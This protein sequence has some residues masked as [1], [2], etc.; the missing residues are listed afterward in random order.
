MLNQV[1]N[2]DC[3]EGMK[4]IEDKSIDMI[5]CDLPYGTTSCK[6]DSIIPFDKLWEQYERIIKDNGAIVLTASQPFTT[7]LIESNIKLFRY[8]WIWK[9]GNHTTGFPNANRMPLK[10]HENILVFYKKLPTYNPQGLIKLENPIKKKKTPNI[11]V[12]G[13][14]NNKSLNKVHVTSYT[15]YP[16]S[17]IDFSRDSK[18]FHPT[19]KPV[20]LF[21]YLIKTYTN[22]GE[23]VLDNCMGSFTTAIACINTNRKYIGF[24]MDEEY[25][26]LGNERVNKHIESLRYP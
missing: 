19:Q 1:L 8:E 20:A 26:T 23:T 4:M 3:L 18:T 21:E 10:N 22:E 7:K 24:E 6:W 9:K 2:M 13:E 25:W 14:R 15:N 11:G 5:L 16:K 17:V 12:F